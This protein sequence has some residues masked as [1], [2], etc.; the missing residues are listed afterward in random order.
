MSIPQRRCCATRR[1]CVDWP[2]DGLVMR[3]WYWAGGAALSA[4]V[5]MCAACSTSGSG[6]SIPHISALITTRSVGPVS[7]REARQ[8]VEHTLG[9]G[10][11]LSTT[12]RATRGTGGR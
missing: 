5:L 2:Y 12:P 10:T 1:A 4:I 8:R 11:L 6:E 7:V 9:H 3:A